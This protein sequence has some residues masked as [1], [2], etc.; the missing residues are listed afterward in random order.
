MK[1]LQINSVCGIRSTGRICTDIAELLCENGHQCRIA[2]GR[3]TAPDEYLKYAYRIGG[4]LDA[5]LHAASARLFDNSGYCS[6]M[7]T[8]RFVKWAESYEFDIVHLHNIHGYYI[9]IQVLFD[10]LKRAGKPIVWTLHDCWA[11]TGHCAHYESV[12]CEKWRIGGCG[13]CPQKTAYPKSIFLDNSKRNFENKKRLYGLQEK[14]TVVTPSHWLGEQVKQSMLCGCEITVINN[15][16][17]KAVFK[18]RKSNFRLRYGLENKKVI[19][20]A[21]SVWTREKG[22]DDIMALSEMI[23]DVCRI[24]MVGVSER[25]MRRMPKNI[26]GIGGTDSGEQ[27]AEIYSAAD[28]FV[29][30][31]YEDTYPTVNLEAQACGTPVVT[32]RTGGSAECV[33]VNHVAEKGCVGELWQRIKQVL[34]GADELFEPSDRETYAMRYMELYEDILI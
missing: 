16:V 14:L 13:K 11:F 33:P 28:V 2:Y 26:V 24:V 7:A 6:K 3:N 29:N 21:A 12:G 31:T 8:R 10:Y 9:N 20:A 34:N 23:D 27:M 1:I 4:E 30:P 22:V 25:Q 18:P 19:L 5:I 32:Y 15:G 17:D